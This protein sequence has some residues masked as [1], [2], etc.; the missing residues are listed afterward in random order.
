MQT[1]NFLST[2]KIT[3]KRKRN[4]KNNYVLPKS[5]LERM[6]NQL[7]NPTNK[8]KENRL[9]NDTLQ[10]SGKGL[11]HQTVSND[12]LYLKGLFFFDEILTRKYKF[13]L[14]KKKIY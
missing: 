6:K 4:V 13:N 12:R 8:N 9:S 11:N 2:A 5:Q 10:I 14:L 7:R 3:G 1:E